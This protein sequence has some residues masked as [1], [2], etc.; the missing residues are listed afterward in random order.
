[1]A[2]SAGSIVMCM[3]HTSPGRDA[4]YDLL[5]VLQ[6]DLLN[7]DW[8][9]ASSLRATEEWRNATDWSRAASE[10]DPILGWLITASDYT[11]SYT[12]HRAEINRVSLSQNASQFQS[13][14]MLRNNFYDSPI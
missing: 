5:L 4:T 3:Q 2:F 14:V 8:E 6:L 1:M 7:I 10:Q 9:A 11:V 12:F 13:I